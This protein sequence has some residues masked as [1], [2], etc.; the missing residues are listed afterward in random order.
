MSRLVFVKGEQRKFLQKVGCV[1]GL[2]SDELGKIVGISGRSF[3][4]WRIFKRAAI[5]RNG[6]R[7]VRDTCFIGLSSV[8]FSKNYCNCLQYSKIIVVILRVWGI[9]IKAYSPKRQCFKRGN[10]LL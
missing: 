7:S 9:F 2:G 1:L 5:Q 8:S 4:D 6:I 3:R 10:L